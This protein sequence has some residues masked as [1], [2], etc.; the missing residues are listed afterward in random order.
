MATG[1]AF[2]IESML[3]TKHLLDADNIQG[4]FC[5]VDT[6]AQRDAL[7]VVRYNPET[8]AVTEDGVIKQG[9][10]VYVKADDTV[11]KWNGEEYVDSTQP[12]KD[13]LNSVESVLDGHSSFVESITELQRQMANVQDA[14]RAN[15]ERFV[16]TGQAITANAW[17]RDFLPDHDR[18]RFCQ[19]VNLTY[20]GQISSVTVNGQVIALESDEQSVIK[21][22]YENSSLNVYYNNAV[23]GN[24]TD[25]IILTV[26]VSASTNGTIDVDY[27]YAFVDYS[28]VDVKSKNGFPITEKYEGE[29][30]YWTR[31]CQTAPYSYQQYPHA[32]ST[33]HALAVY[34]IGNYTGDGDI[35]FRATFDKNSYIVPA[36]H[37][38]QH[39]Y[40]ANWDLSG[41][42]SYQM[43]FAA[44]NSSNITDKPENQFLYDKFC[45]RLDFTKVKF[46]KATKPNNKRPAYN[47]RGKTLGS[48]R[49]FGNVIAGI[50]N[51][52]IEFG[53]IY[54]VKSLGDLSD[55]DVS[56]V[57]T[58]SEMFSRCFAVEFIGDIAKW[59]VTS[60]ATEIKN[61]FRNCYN[62][63]GISSAISDWD[64]SN[65][66]KTN[67]MFEDTLWIGDETLKDLGKW[68]MSNNLSLN[69]MFCYFFA[70]NTKSN[71]YLL[72]P[73]EYRHII[74]NLYAIG[75][76]Q[77]DSTRR[78]LEEENIGLIRQVIRKPKTDLSFVDEW[79]THSVE[80]LYYMFANNPYLTN[81]GD[82]RKWN[83]SG[84][85]TDEAL[86]SGHGACGM[87]QYCTALET[88]RLPSIP[89]GVDVTDI[90]R[91]CTS[92]ANVE[93]NQ[94]NVEAIDFGDC[95]LTK[96][97]VLNLIN[98]ATDN[99]SITLSAATYAA[100]NGDAD[101]TAARDEKAVQNII[102]DLGM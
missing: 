24:I 59:K 94:L 32:L 11:Y 27:T 60:A 101:V 65:I 96:Q 42:T 57:Q 26:E 22:V 69:Y 75:E 95:P 25:T 29:I 50:D 3:A 10:L 19:E 6:I 87:F 90:V 13:N 78:N 73:Q 40:M 28:D 9:S 8:G 17:K 38:I 74:D 12:I 63:R 37:V 54:Y 7:P 31:K 30:E 41:I 92:L 100:V 4:G 45:K 15:R 33:H 68:N 52:K 66:T 84:M 85:I 62:L 51:A 47:F 76:A 14:M 93:L 20:D 83:M 18:S 36:D 44:E 53:R 56:R 99:V 34:S 98:A 43:M 5:T 67:D 86:T 49:G 48:L 23:A 58:F 102:V 91:G 71:E 35:L 81:V 2:Q 89:R 82:L 70:G 88:L 39:I 97:S 1:F 77:D 61:F 80:R 72:V 46:S 55:F 79:D 21:V 64:T 16:L